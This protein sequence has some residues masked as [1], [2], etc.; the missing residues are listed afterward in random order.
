MRS[1]IVIGIL[2][3]FFGL[4]QSTVF[5]DI[6]RIEEVK[7]DLLLIVV[8]F[9]AFRYGAMIGQCSGFAAGMMQQIFSPALLG[10]YAFVFT[11]IGFTLSI[12]RH[13]INADNFITSVLI[14]FLAT[15]LKGLMLGFLALCFGEL[16]DM[17]GSYIVNAFLLELVLNPILAGPLIWLLNRFAAPAMR[18]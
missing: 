8:S 11:V 10:C 6:L 4:L 17:Y 7:P 5:I 14:V 9:L 18:M 2:I 12:A 13:K 1:V 3:L 16:G 15:L